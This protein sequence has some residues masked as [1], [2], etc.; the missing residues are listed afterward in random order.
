MIELGSGPGRGDL[1]EPHLEIGETTMK[2]TL[3]LLTVLL[4]A[5]LAALPAHAAVPPDMFAEI[6][7]VK[8][9]I[10]TGDWSRSSRRSCRTCRCRWM[11]PVS[12]AGF[13][14][15][16]KITTAEQFA[17]SWNGSASGMS[18]FFATLRP[19]WPARTPAADRVVRLAHRDGRRLL[20]R[21]LAAR[22]WEAA[23][24][25]G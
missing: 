18:R 1:L 15:A 4:L 12:C 14:L 5:P 7:R 11:P 2:P 21:V 24:G 6:G 20:P 16:E 3:T 23:S 9:T 25:R 17:R 10:A 22:S 8:R 19:R 13:R